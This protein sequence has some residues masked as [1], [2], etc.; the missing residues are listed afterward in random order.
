[1]DPL[2]G[3]WHRVSSSNV[4]AVR[5]LGP[6]L[7]VR[8]QGKRR[9]PVRTWRYEGAGRLLESLLAAPSAGKFVWHVLR[10]AYGDGVE[11]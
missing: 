7:E 11:V 4:E 9:Q 2:D 1:M 10:P 8:F 6:D 3:V 5:R